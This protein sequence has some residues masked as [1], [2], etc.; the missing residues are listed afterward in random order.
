MEK[1]TGEDGFEMGQRSTEP[2]PKHALLRPLAQGPHHWGG[3]LL[4]LSPIQGPGLLP[5]ITLIVGKGLPPGNP[6]AFTVSS[7]QDSLYP[8]T[9][10]VV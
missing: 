10:W 3:G 4:T 7:V 5:E 8:G 6:N 1:D 9:S 2:K